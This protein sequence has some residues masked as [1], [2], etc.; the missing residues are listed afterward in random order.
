MAMLHGILSDLVLNLDRMVTSSQLHQMQIQFFVLLNMYR[1]WRGINDNGEGQL[2]DHSNLLLEALMTAKHSLGQQQVLDF[3]LEILRLRRIA[4]LEVL[5]IIIKKIKSSVEEATNK[6]ATQEI[7][8]DRVTET[9]RLKKVALFKKVRE[10]VL[11]NP[12]FNTQIKEFETLILTKNKLKRYSLVQDNN[13]GELC[14]GILEILQT[15]LKESR[16]KILQDLVIDAIPDTLKLGKGQWFKC[17]Y[18]HVT[19]LADRDEPKCSLCQEDV[20]I[21]LISKARRL[22]TT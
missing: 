4:Q 11:E 22:K 20:T 1:M 18:G 5:N 7:C 13:A 21:T 15:N 16:F 8:L 14:K 12:N 6:Y 19:T 17:P 3:R 9:I 10:Q 2:R